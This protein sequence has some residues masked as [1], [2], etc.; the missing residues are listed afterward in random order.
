[1]SGDPKYNPVEV[2]RYNTFFLASKY[3]HLIS[4]V[5]PATLLLRSRGAKLFAPILKCQ[6]PFILH[7][8]VF[9]PPTSLYV[10][11]RI[12]KL[13]ATLRNC[14][15]NPKDELNLQFSLN[16]TQSQLPSD[17]KI[18]ETYQL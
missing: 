12:I 1:V 11:L 9:T 4:E 13:A 8:F 2:G 17:R 6:T 14:K 3:L 16:S 10:A 18:N 15:N 7:Y 5:K